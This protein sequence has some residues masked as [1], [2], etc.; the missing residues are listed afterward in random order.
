VVDYSSDPHAED[1]NLVADFTGDRLKEWL[2]TD[3]QER[4]VDE[5]GKPIGVRWSVSC[6]FSW[7]M[8]SAD[9]AVHVN[10]LNWEVIKTLTLQYGYVPCPRS[11][12]IP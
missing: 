4:P 11:A 8:I 12:F 7:T 9:T 2:E 3:G 10:G 5:D 1:S 6:C